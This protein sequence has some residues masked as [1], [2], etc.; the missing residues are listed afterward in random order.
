MNTISAVWLCS[1]LFQATRNVVSTKEN[2]V[3]EEVLQ[4]N[5]DN[6]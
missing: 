5:T 1:H 6:R 4:R 3:I 2:L